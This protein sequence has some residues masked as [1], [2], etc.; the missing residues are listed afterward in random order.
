MSDAAFTDSTT[1]QASPLATLRPACGTSTNTTSPSCSWAS[2]VMP[3]VPT[4][5]STRI[6]SCSW[7]YL[8]SAIWQ[9]LSAV[10][11]VLDER[12]G[13]DLRRHGLAAHQQFDLGAVGRAG[14]L[15]IAHG[16]GAPERRREAARCDLADGVAGDGDFRAFTR[17][18]LAFGQQADALARRSLDDLLLDDGRPRKTALRAALLADA[19]KQARLDRRRRGVD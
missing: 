1:A 7:E 8:V 13:H 9:L 19:P 4:S 18:R 16:D 3:M 15:D 10:V 14:A 5:P 17:D 6:H 11:G 12:H 2:G